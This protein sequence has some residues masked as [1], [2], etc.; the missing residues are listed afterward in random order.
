M[1]A[2]RAVAATHKGITDW[3]NDILLA[4]H[5]LSEALRKWEATTVKD[6]ATVADLESVID[7]LITSE[8]KASVLRGEV[9]ARRSFLTG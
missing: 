5:H 4:A 8:T 1:Q 7:S 6:E 2:G 9:L 3:Q